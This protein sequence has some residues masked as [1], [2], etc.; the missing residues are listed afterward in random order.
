M[1]H[2]AEI[3]DNNIVVRVL[4][5]D[6]NSP[7]EGEAMMNSLGGRWVKTSY[8][9]NFNG[10]RKNFAG[11][12]GYYDEAKDAFIPPKP[13]NSWVLD[14]EICRWVPPTPYP[15]PSVTYYWD[16]ITDNWK[17]MTNE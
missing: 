10:F 8:N 12:G 14:E 16:E 7:D 11:I 6:N 13:Y 9:A 2:W 15:T 3:D 1:S 5:G 4:V 17:E